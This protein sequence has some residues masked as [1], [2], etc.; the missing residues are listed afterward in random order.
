MPLLF[1]GDC[2]FCT[3]GVALLR[4]W[5]APRAASIPY[6]EADLDALG[7]AENE[8]EQA[9]QWVGAGMRA[10]GADAI[11][12]WLATA[13]RRRPLLRLITV[14]LPLGRALYPTVVRNRGSLGRMMRR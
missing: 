8:C 14:G 2:G 10:S 7:V 11:A 13:C 6:Q 9:V 4:R 12:A 5:F 1:D 3:D